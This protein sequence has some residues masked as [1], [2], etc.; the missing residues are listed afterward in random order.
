MRREREEN[1]TGRGTGATERK[2]GGRGPSSSF[3]PFGQ[4][5]TIIRGVKV[6]TGEAVGPRDKLGNKWERDEGVVMA[7][8]SKKEGSRMYFKWWVGR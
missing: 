5:N 6:D 4:H 1:M 3:P 2:F 8:R 7:R